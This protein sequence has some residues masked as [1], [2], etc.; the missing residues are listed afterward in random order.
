MLFVL[1][2]RMHKLG[3][4]LSLPLRSLS[5][6]HDAIKHGACLRRYCEVRFVC[7]C[8]ILLLCDMGQKKICSSILLYNVILVSSISLTIILLQHRQPSP[9]V[10]AVVGLSTCSQQ[11]APAFGLSCFDEQSHF[12]S[13]LF[14][15]HR[16]ALLCVLYVHPALL[17]C[18]SF[19]L[20]VF[21][22]IK[23]LVFIP[24]SPCH[25][26]LSYNL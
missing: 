4:V 11:W 8:D 17:F 5:A 7:C 12:S 14:L 3:M 19:F 25:T 6:R 26:Q 13:A 16:Y 15:S 24:D 9:A 22:F 1:L 2:H 21:I 10:S 20:S 23:F 18:V